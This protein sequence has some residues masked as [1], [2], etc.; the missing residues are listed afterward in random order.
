MSMYIHYNKSK[1]TQLFITVHAIEGNNLK[2]GAEGIFS[3]PPKGEAILDTK[4]AT[5][6]ALRRARQHPAEA[7]KQSHKGKYLRSMC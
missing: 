4:R 2:V 1:T 6:G 3:R 5:P 7:R